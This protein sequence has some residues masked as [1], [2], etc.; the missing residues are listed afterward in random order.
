MKKIKEF[1]IGQS[2]ED[3]LNGSKLV[4]DINA[5]FIFCIDDKG[6]KLKLPLSSFGVSPHL[7]RFFCK[8][9]VEFMNY[10]RVDTPILEL[11]DVLYY[12]KFDYNV[13]VRQIDERNIYIESEHHF[14]LKNIRYPTYCKQFFFISSEPLKL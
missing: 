6:N 10:D 7:A 8:R 5:E 11:G 9:K 13:I 4:F 1:I 12:P 14:G 2:W 3:E